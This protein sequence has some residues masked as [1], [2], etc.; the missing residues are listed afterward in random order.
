M[1]KFT[2]GYILEEDEFLLKISG[3]GYREHNANK[4]FL[5][6]FTQKG[7]IPLPFKNWHP[8]LDIYVVKE[9]FRKGWKIVGFREGM[10][11]TWVILVHPNN[12]TLEINISN[13]INLLKEITI[14]KGE[15]IGEFR[16]EDHNLIQK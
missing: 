3:S 12:Y 14:D 4:G 11:T 6:K 16:W 7:K 1:R 2:E 13:F 8:D 10:S 9:E 5:T 15:L